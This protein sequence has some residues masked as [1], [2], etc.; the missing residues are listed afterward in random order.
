MI[1]KELQI[2]GIDWCLFILSAVLFVL[3]PLFF[4]E[5]KESEWVSGFIPIR[6]VNAELKI[7]IYIIITSLIVGVS[8]IRVHLENR[9]NSVSKEIYIFGSIF[10]ISVIISTFLAHNTERAFV[11][12]FIWHVLPVLFAFSLFQIN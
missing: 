12:S 7:C 9:F 11:Y 8:W 6:M 5:L 10:F 3:T 4:I 1:K 2:C